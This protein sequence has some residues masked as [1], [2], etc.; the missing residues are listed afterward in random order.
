VSDRIAPLPDA[1]STVYW[2]AAREGRLLIQRCT[3]CR[4]YQF[5]P[6][7][8]CAGCLAAE[9]EWVTAAGRG[10]LHSFTTVHR[11]PN[12]EFAALTPYVFALVDLDEG[13]RITTNVV[14]VGDRPLRCGD[15]VRIV[16]TAMADGVNLPCATPD[17]DGVEAAP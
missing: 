2:A 5:Y 1:F 16:F 7:Q 12:A 14:E 13:V 11:T 6:R 10:T 3:Q 15:R 8:H 9:P 4:R 17:F